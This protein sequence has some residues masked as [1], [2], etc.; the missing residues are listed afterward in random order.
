MRLEL[1]LRDEGIQHEE[2]NIDNMTLNEYFLQ[3]H[4][5]SVESSNKEWETKF[6]RWRAAADKAVVR[7]DIPGSRNLGSR[8]YD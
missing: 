1:W 4:R 2:G 5:R 6:G 3:C 8:D 7:D